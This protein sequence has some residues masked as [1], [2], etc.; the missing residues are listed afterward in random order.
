VS[1]RNNISENIISNNVMGIYFWIMGNWNNIT[2]NTISNNSI[3]I[4][5]MG[6]IF[7]NP[8]N[9][10]IFHNNFIDNTNQSFD[11]S[12]NVNKWDNGYPSGGN[13]WS[14]YTGSDNRNGPNQDMPGY[15]GIGDTPYEIDN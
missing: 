12:V 13:Y 6:L 9:N 5:I 1:D 11:S 14:D 8:E 7:V 15:D 3:G 10:S 4:F 2:L